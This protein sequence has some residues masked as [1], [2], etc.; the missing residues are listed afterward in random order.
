LTSWRH[1]ALVE[2]LRHKIEDI[3]TLKRKLTQSKANLV[4]LLKEI[5]ARPDG[6]DCATNARR[7]LSQLQ[8]GKIKKPA[9]AAGDVRLLD[10]VS[11]RR[12]V[13]AR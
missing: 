12:P 7:V 4:A 3:E 13:R 1:G 2:T 9:L 10:K 5:E 6:I 8:R 11:R